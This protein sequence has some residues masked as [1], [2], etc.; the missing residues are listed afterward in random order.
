MTPERPAALIALVCFAHVLTLMGVFAFPAL[1]PMFIAEWSLTNAQAGWIS[2]IP[3]AANAISVSV[4]VSL[5]DRIDARYIFGAGA[6]LGALALAGFALL[7]SG[8]WSALI[9]RA[10]AGVEIG[11]A[12]V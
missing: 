11:R 9:F 2:G 6:L 8:F 4:L 3:L 12:H 1:L 7:A 5:T 10:L